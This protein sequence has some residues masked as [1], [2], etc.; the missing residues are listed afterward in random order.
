MDSDFASDNFDQTSEASELENQQGEKATLESSNEI[1]LICNQEETVSK[2][3]LGSDEQIPW[4]SQSI[5]QVDSA[6][7]N[8]SRDCHLQDDNIRQTSTAR[9]YPTEETVLTI[10]EKS[11]AVIDVE[12]I[13]ETQPKDIAT[14]PDK[15]SYQQTDTGLMEKLN[16]QSNSKQTSLSPRLSKSNINSWK[17]SKFVPVGQRRPASEPNISDFE[18]LETLPKCNRAVVHTA[19]LCFSPVDQTV[20]DFDSSRHTLCV[21]KFTYS[22]MQKYSNDLQQSCSSS[23]APFQN[24]KLP[25][26]HFK[27]SLNREENTLVLQSTEDNLYPGVMTFAPFS[28]LK[29]ARSNIRIGC[30]N[31]NAKRAS[32]SAGPNTSGNGSHALQDPCMV[33]VESKSWNFEIGA[34]GSKGTNPARVLLPRTGLSNRSASTTSIG[35][36]ISLL[37]QYRTKDCLEGFS[38][39]GHSIICKTIRKVLD[40]NRF[41]DTDDMWAKFASQKEPCQSVLHTGY[42][43]IQVC[44]ALH[45]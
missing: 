4:Q 44:T 22:N 9:P 1:S 42:P 31:S 28:A 27:E 14:V 30:K 24:I 11:C 7:E 6:Q 41:M 18:P 2:G 19:R 43:K 5:H 33:A 34:Q 21:E 39:A 10:G 15:Q 29:T 17:K 16:R 40:D 36:C 35:D 20:G 13:H 25:P 8:G 45:L 3:G 38:R 12:R 37:W 26:K 23:S 32:R